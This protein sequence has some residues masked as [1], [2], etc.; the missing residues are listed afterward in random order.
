MQS[1]AACS[2]PP[3]LAR[4]LA[5]ALSAHCRASG[6]RPMCAR[7]A[8]PINVKSM[9]YSATFFPYGQCLRI[10]M[11]SKQSHPLERKIPIG[12]KR[13]QSNSRF[14]ACNCEVSLAIHREHIAASQGIGIVRVELNG[15]STCFFIR[16]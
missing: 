1:L 5:T 12:M 4:S 2:G 3:G 11:R 8:A 6:R 15:R 13:I 16:S 14:A 9:K 7:M 10:P